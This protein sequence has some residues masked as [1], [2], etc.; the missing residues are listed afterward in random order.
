MQLPTALQKTR[1]HLACFSDG[2][3]R[4]IRILLCV[5]KYGLATVE[6]ACALAFLQGGCNYTVILSHLQ[7]KLEAPQPTV[8][9]PALRHPPTAACTPYNII[10]LSQDTLRQG[11]RHVT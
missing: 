2:D 5:P 9:R 6:K 4:F 7:P 3:K 1:D 10:Y 8:I 11:A